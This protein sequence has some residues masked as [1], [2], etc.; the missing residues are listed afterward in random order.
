MSF[1]FDDLMGSA[2]HKEKA[3]KASSEF[4][5][6]DMG[7]PA[8]LYAYIK[9]RVDVGFNDEGKHQFVFPHKGAWGFTFK[10]FNT[11]LYFTVEDTG[12]TITVKKFEEGVVKDWETRPVLQPN[13]IISAE[14][15]EIAMDKAKFLTSAD[16][17]EDLPAKQQAWWEQRAESLN[18]ILNEEQ[19]M[20]EAYAR[21]LWS[22]DEKALAIS[23]NW[24]ENIKD[25][26]VPKELASKVSSVK[27][28]LKNQA[29]RTLNFD[30]DT[31]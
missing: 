2:E 15:K 4:Q 12:K 14:T 1:D 23:P 10:A 19:P 25:S 30:R 18:K 8:T 20:V 5:K 21:H 11:P 16:A 31:V 17:L 29:M 13:F 24:I 3:T 7:D 26:N 27:Q 22:S 9:S 28:R 6:S